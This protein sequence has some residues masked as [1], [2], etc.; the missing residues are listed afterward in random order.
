MSEWARV[1]KY[2]S[3]PSQLDLISYAPY[4]FVTHS[5]AWQ[6]PQGAQLVLQDLAHENG[7]QCEGNNQIRI[8]YV[9]AA[10][11]RRHYDLHHKEYLI[12]GAGIFIDTGNIH[13]IG[14]HC[15]SKYKYNYKYTITHT[16]THSI[17]SI[18]I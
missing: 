7:K 4:D 2:N 11:H 9:H 10:A 18:K 13:A 12:G 3:L 14:Q 15:N 17:N 8:R 5:N 1:M 16:H 6:L